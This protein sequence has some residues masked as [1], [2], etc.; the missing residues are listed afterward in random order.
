VGNV[1]ATNTYTYTLNPPP[2]PPAVLTGVTLSP[3]GSLSFSVTNAGGVYR[4]QANTNLANVASWINV[5]TNTAP[6]TFTVT[7]V[8]GGPPQSFYRV[9][10]P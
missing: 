5:S 10:T 1:S 2:S 6:F 3:G 9:V 7:N 4:V 8:P